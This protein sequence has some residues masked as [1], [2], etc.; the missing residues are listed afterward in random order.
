MQSRTAHVSKDDPRRVEKMAA[1]TASREGGGSGVGGDG[2]REG[3][4]VVWVKGTG[5]CVQ[6]ALQ[7]ASFF[8]GKG[9][10]GV[11]LRTGSVWAVDDVVV[12]ED[13]DDRGDGGGDVSEDEEEIPETRTR[14]VSVLEV[15][16]WLKG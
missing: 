9:D 2:P 5:R 15:G 16:L 7:V 12:D 3:Q 13:E 6:R 14:Q 1:V 4:E 8:Q 11:W 10:V